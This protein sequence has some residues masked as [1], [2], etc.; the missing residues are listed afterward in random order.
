M[1]TIIIEFLYFELFWL[2]NNLL[3]CAHAKATKDTKPAM[4]YTKTYKYMIISVSLKGEQSLFNYS[5]VPAGKKYSKLHI[6]NYMCIKCTSIIAITLYVHICID[7]QIYLF[8]K[9]TK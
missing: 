3:V 8:N 9:N 2:M 7:V 4:Y 5:D 6:Y 1:Q